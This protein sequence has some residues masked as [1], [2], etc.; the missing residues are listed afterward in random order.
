M[1]WATEPS[2]LA[3]FQYA[4][5]L[6]LE[7]LSNEYHRAKEAAAQNPA[8]EKGVQRVLWAGVIFHRHAEVIWNKT[9][10]GPWQY[11]RRW[12]RWQWETMPYERI[13]YDQERA[14]PSCNAGSI[15]QEVLLHLVKGVRDPR[16]Q[17]DV[18]LAGMGRS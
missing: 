14:T 9:G 12:S 5:A 10:T 6:A 17:K 13:E 2:A 16:A 4:L 8:K 3:N 7:M 15:P 11:K 1:L 18:A